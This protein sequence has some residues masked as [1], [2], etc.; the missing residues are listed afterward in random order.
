MLLRTTTGREFF[1]FLW[2]LGGSLCSSGFCIHNASNRTRVPTYI[3][4][5]TLYSLIITW[6]T[7]DTG[8]YLRMDYVFI[9][10]L[11]TLYFRSGSILRL[12][13]C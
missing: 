13:C 9:L 8:K 4:M 12:C 10:S 2:Q 11:M 7:E 3:G 1:D 5:S 6:F